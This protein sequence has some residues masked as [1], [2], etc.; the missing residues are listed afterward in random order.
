[1]PLP[2]I[3]TIYTYTKVKLL[4]KNE[5]NE[6][7]N[8]YI[9]LFKFIKQN[10]EKLNL[11]KIENEIE[12]IAEEITNNIGFKFEDGKL[13][14]QNKH[15]YPIDI[16]E[17]KRLRLES[18]MDEINKIDDFIKDKFV[19]KN[20]FRA[21]QCFLRIPYFFENYEKNIFDYKTYNGYKKIYEYFKKNHNQIYKRKFTG[22]RVVEENRIIF[23]DSYIEN[24]ENWL[25]DYRNAFTEYILN[26]LILD[27]EVK[28]H[29]TY[30]NRILVSTNFTDVLKTI[31]GISIMEYLKIIKKIL[32]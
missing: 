16:Y 13:K 2:I 8:K 3:K 31:L 22:V 30:M 23:L 20:I 14:V 10:I 32:Y 11:Y 26:M 1:M 19:R 29:L 15:S 4:L 7:K 24:C 6:L 12:C 27:Y 28:K 17:K 5:C 25:K 9:C 18:I 21:E